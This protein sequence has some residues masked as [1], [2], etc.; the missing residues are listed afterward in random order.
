MTDRRAVVAFINQHK[1]EFYKK[2]DNDIRDRIS[3]RIDIQ[4]FAQELGY[5]VR[6]IGRYFTLEE[7][8]SVRIYRQKKRFWRNSHPGAGSA[9]GAGGDVIDFA[10]MFANMDMHE[11]LT[12]FTNRVQRSIKQ[13]PARERQTWKK[14]ETENVSLASK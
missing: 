14:Q 8:D 2:R 11:A 1:Y 13:G 10:V 12:Y 4:D 5:H 3:R 6:R 9:I 7:Y